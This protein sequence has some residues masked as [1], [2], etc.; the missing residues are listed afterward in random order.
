MEVLR[1][2]RIKARLSH[3]ELGRL[4]NV[5]GKTVKRAEEGKPVQELKAIAIVE[6]LG[7]A[8][9]KKLSVSDIEG[10]SIY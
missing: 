6:A 9:G 10:L 3:S 8:V 5:D 1:D 2:L 7:N 4:A